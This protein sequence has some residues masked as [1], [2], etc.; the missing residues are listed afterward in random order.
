M[1]LRF[2]RLVLELLSPEEAI[3]VSLLLCLNQQ[4]E[5]TS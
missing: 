1:S 5:E 4:R 2:M 3:I